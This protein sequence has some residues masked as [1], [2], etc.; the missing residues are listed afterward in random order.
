MTQPMY[1]GFEQ[2]FF[3][4]LNAIVEPAV[5]RGIGSPAL[6]PTALIL[7]ESVGF[8]SGLQRTTPLLSF[9]AG[10]YRIVSTVRSD[11]SFWVKNLIRQPQVNYFVGGKKRQA[12]AVVLLDGE[13]ATANRHQTPFL[14]ALVA[15]FSRAT[16]GGLAVA[17]LVPTKA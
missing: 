3:R 16:R 13:P 14:N 8:K 6:L 17:I 1:A 2:K 4:T 15:L 12:H 7:L 5:R 11:R 10:R 9:R